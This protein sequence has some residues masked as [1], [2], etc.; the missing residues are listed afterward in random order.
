MGNRGGHL[1]RFC[2][3]GIFWPFHFRTFS[4]KSLSTKYVPFSFSSSDTIFRHPIFFHAFSFFSPS[5][6]IRLFFFLFLFFFPPLLT[7]VYF[8]PADVVFSPFSFSF[9]PFSIFCPFPFYFLFCQLLLL[10]FFDR[11]PTS[12]SAFGLQPENSASKQSR[13]KRGSSKERR[14]AIRVQRGSS[15]ERRQ[16]IGV[17]RGK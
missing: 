12:I 1:T 16:A 3:L 14:Q 7:L 15:K 2:P 11:L 5:P 6:Y 10:G 13:K 9:S 4:S 17:Q 8:P